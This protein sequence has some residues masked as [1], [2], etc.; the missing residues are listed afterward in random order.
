[1]AKHFNDLLIRL[2]TQALG[3][4][5]ALTALAAVIVRG[6]L[7]PTLR[8]ELLVGAF[9]LLIF[10]WIAV[11][12]LDARYYNRLLFGAV[13]AILEI[14]EQSKTGR[15]LDGLDLSTRIE[16][17]VTKGKA[18]GPS[19]AQAPVHR[20][21]SIVLFALL[22]GL[23][24]SLAGL[25]GFGLTSQSVVRPGVTGIV[26]D[27]TQDLPVVGATVRLV[28][29]RD[30]ENRATAVTGSDGGFSLNPKRTWGLHILPSEPEQIQFT[31]TLE[32]QG[33]HTYTFQFAHRTYSWIET[34]N[35]GR[36]LLQQQ[37]INVRR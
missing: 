16:A 24:V 14:E 20:F 36:I 29:S 30:P 21:Y 26:H 8:W 31:L 37:K 23:G 3:G 7:V 27:S 34:T 35:C 32:R 15:P 17:A 4:A 10:F 9:V 18:S 33:F 12:V 19:R 13:N 1:M 28:S 5:A 25:A 2:R 11:W 22:T 6:D